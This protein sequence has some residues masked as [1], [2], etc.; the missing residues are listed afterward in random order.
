ML[1]GFVAIVE[2]VEHFAGVELGAAA[3][4]VAATG[5]GGGL[6]VVLH[7]VGDVVLTAL[8]V[9]EAEVSHVEARLDEVAGLFGVGENF[10]VD[11]DGAGAVAGVLGEIGDLE[12][13]EIVV[14]ILVGEAFLDDDGLGVAGVV[15]EEERERGAGLDGRDDAVG[16]GLAEEF[17]A[18]FLVAA[19]AGDADHDAKEARQAGDG[20]LLD[21]DGHLGVGV[22]GIDFEGLLAVAARGEALTGS[23]C[24]SCVPRE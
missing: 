24:R 5:L 12:A 16:G 8:G 22:A 7:G 1:D 3:E 11:G 18:F 20:E 23:G 14:G 6:Q 4:P 2:E 21:A 19:D 10:A 15:A 17:E 9:G 13:E